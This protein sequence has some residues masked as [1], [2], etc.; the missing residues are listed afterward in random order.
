MIMLALA[1]LRH[2]VAA[3]LAT[4]IA[5]L[6]GSAILIACGGL[7]E[8]AIRLD[9]PP[10]R[11]AGAPVVITGPS[12]FALPDQESETVAYA[13]RSGV[14]AGLAAK[15]AAIPGVE[16]AVADVSF[17]AV[18]PGSSDVLAGHSWESAVLTPYTLTAGAEPRAGQVVLNARSGARPGDK[19]DIVVAG[20]PASFTVSGVAQG[21]ADAVFFSASDTQKYWSRPGTVDLIGV[22][23]GS[24]PVEELA[25]QV[26]AG[27]SVL[28]GD[29][30]GAAEFSGIDASFLPLILLAAIFG[31]MM[32]VV[33]ALVVA[34]T[35]SLSARQRQQ[36]LALLRATGATPKQVHRMVVAETMAVSVLAAVGG[37]GLGALMGEWIYSLSASRGVVPAALEFHQGLI[38]FAG[39]T[40]VALAIAWLAAYLAARVA[41]RARPIQALAEA[42]IPDVTLSPIRLLLAKVFG[43]A[44]IGLAVSTIFLDPETASAVGGPAVLTGVITVGLLG[45][46]LVVKATEL[47]RRPQDDLAVI[48]TRSRAVQ[49]AAVLTPITLAAAI[50]LGNIYTQTTKEEAAIS[51]Y[52][53]QIETDAVVSSANGGIA[54][55]LVADVRKVPGVSSVTE[56]VSSH[57][58]IE[59]PYD[60]RGSDPWSL[61]GIDGDAFVV[62]A[63]AGSMADL[64]GNSVALPV[65][66]AEDLSLGVGSQVKMRLGDG[67][68][69]EVKVVALLDSPDYYGSLVLPADLLARH[70]T[71]G[72]PTELLVRGSDDVAEAV[73]QRLQAW[74]GT[75]VG[76]TLSVQSGLDVEGWINY[77]LAALAIA[78][79]AIA[80]VNTLVVSVLARRREFAVQRLAG[81]T[82]Q[83]VTRMLLVE[84]GI[85]AV[86]S[87]VLGTVIAGIS[88][89]SMAFAAGSIV[90]SGPI[91]VFLAVVAATFLIVWPATFIAARHAMKHRPLP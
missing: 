2:R 76:D 42:A 18:L 54:P 74:P 53:S 24:V 10:Q 69:V 71:T 6:L 13:E 25:R 32:L 1:S 47:T 20:K 91:W 46:W 23:P 57:G 52:L 64:A 14:D 89:V 77:L 36:E 48:N 31:G 38:P 83:Q 43:V 84:S 59:E 22:F 40:V 16:R 55:D 45:P 61:M 49:F 88:V 50:A 56:L 58:W 34:A 44:T 86:A 90:P 28:T 3:S 75:S 39:G 41:A 80:A 68:Q 60:S 7:F 5:V 29:D 78:Y 8:T 85:V 62:P 63:T 35:I 70:T 73:G 26:P 79:A 67:A 72:L 19:I 4:F 11:L 33:M 65:S 12:G 87:L 51:G 82:R 21:L 27:L 15:I 81:A 9:A 37:I 17:P 30:R 66:Q